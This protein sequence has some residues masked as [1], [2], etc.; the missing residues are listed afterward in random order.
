MLIG[1]VLLDLQESEIG[2]LVGSDDGCRHGFAIVQG[3]GDFGR[4]FDYV[5]VRDNIAIGGD[6]EPRA[7]RLGEVRLEVTIARRSFLRRNV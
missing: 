1:T 3:H 2:F 6:N 4:V 7:L 5:V